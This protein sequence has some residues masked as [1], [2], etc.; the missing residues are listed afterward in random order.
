MG[1][2]LAKETPLKYPVALSIV[3]LTSALALRPA[4]AAAQLG[5]ADYVV[6]TWS[7]KDGLAFGQ[8]QAIEQDADG[9]LWLGTDAG[10]VRFDG[11][12]FVPSRAL[13]LG[14]KVPEATVMSLFR[15]RD[16]TVW[17]GFGGSAAM[18]PGSVMPM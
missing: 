13:G 15:S 1:E 10:L 11:V 14:T 16:G 8:I 2:H 5:L 18:M 4:V 9:Y 12:R 3:M 7:G 17:V 6:T